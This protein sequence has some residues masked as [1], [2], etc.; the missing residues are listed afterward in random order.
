MM[1]FV[2]VAAVVALV[3]PSALAGQVRLESRPVPSLRVES[4]TFQSPSMGLRFA[5]NVGVPKS[6]RAGE[7]RTFPLLVTTDGDWIFPIVQQTASL[8]IDENAIEE[9]FV[10]SI[11]T[12]YDDGMESWTSRRIYEFSPPGWDRQD[13]FGKL[14]TG[15]CQSIKSPEGRCTGGAPEFLRVITAELIPAITAKYS[16]DRE[17]LGLFGVSA[18]GFFATWAMFQAES[19]FRNY[20]ISSPAAAYGNLEV[21]R[22]E[23]QWAA[24]HKDLP[25]SAYFGAG[26]IEMQD[27][28]YEGIGHITSGMMRLVGMLGSRKY[29][30][31]RVTTE[32]H[33]GM[34]HNDVV[35]TVVARGL[36]VLYPRAP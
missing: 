25:V 5:V 24:S 2:R 21:L 13:P 32:M 34:S 28:M 12:S 35:G 4:F 7:N 30:G 22:L 23:E 29:P 6:Y 8:L 16:I 19:P 27:P 20:L 36:R 11:G 33:P 26:S 18:G 31:L 10:V 3:G 14:L 9:L 1:S 15:F 17:R